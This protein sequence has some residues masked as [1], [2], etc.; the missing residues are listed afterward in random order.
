MSTSP[1]R[2]YA[3]AVPAPPAWVTDLAA[4]FSHP[5]AFA[6]LLLPERFRTHPMAGLLHPV[7]PLLCQGLERL[8][9]GIADLV[10]QYPSVP[11]DPATIE[12]ILFAV[13]PAQVIRMMGRT[14]ALEVNVMRLQGLLAGDTPEARFRQFHRAAAPARARARPLAASTPCWRARL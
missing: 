7:Q 1:S 8:R 5:S 4:A 9:A 3:I 10:R 6:P 14:V 2:A 12:D 13:L 11:F